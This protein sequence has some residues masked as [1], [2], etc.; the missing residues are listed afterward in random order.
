MFLVSFIELFFEYN[1]REE[2]INKVKRA[3]ER[4]KKRRER[5][6]SFLHCPIHTSKQIDARIHAVVLLL[7]KTFFKS[8]QKEKEKLHFDN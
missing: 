5:V 4:E 7:Y 6:L 8:A 2:L 3:S 1:E